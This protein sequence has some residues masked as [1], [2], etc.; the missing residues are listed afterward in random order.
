MNGDLYF[1]GELWPEV[2]GRTLIADRIDWT[3]NS[4]SDAV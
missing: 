3:E 4:L 1:T 2:Q